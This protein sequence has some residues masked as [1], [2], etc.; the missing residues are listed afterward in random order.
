VSGQR[1]R[2]LDRIGVAVLTVCGVL[3]GGLSALLVPLYAG[4]TIMPVAVPVAVAANIVLPRLAHALVPTTTA[5]ALPFLGWL[6]VVLGFA[7]VTRPEGDV[8][9]PGGSLQWVTYGVLLG[10]LA[11][12]V[13]TLVLT[14]PPAPAS[15]WAPAPAPASARSGRQDGP[16]S[17][18]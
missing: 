1:A 4:S 12:G 5:T 2:A 16:G 7:V 11:A 9:L 15:S 6:V 3:A 14:T 18:R 13:T 10:G 8:I 17:R